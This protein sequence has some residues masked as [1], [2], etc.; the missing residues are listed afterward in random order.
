MAAGLSAGDVI[1]A[2]DGI[3]VDTSNFEQLLKAYQA[4]DEVS[5]HAFRRDELRSFTVQLAQSEQNTA[6]ASFSQHSPNSKALAWL[7]N[8]ND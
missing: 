4:G 3:K 5:V 6:Y 1:I 8:T 2:I 7:F